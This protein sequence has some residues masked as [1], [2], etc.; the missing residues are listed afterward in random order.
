VGVIPEEWNLITLKR[1]VESN[2]ISSGVY[3]NISLYGRG[4][5]IIKL[6]DVF[7]YDYFKPDL[8]Q[9]VELSYEEISNYSV[10]TGD[11]LIALASVK[12]EGVGK[13]MLVEFLDEET[14][15]DHNVAL[16]RLVKTVDQKYIF[17]LFKSYI[18]RKFVSMRATQV[19]TTFLK[20]STILEFLLPLPSTKAEQQAI[21]NALSDAD[22]LIESLEKL[23]TKKRNIKQGAMQELLTGK[24]RLP[25]FSG[26]WVVRRLDTVAEIRSGGT[27]S[28]NQAEFWNGDILWCT[29]TDITALN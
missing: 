16:I 9:R 12:L 23:I 26:E 20:S 4:K 10:K 3:K 25:G 1:I 13:V 27:P 24:K 28:T 15:Y 18:V 5:K 7:G 29:P 14:A 22:A 8:A 21:V 11:I 17:Y 2:K 6:G 19:G